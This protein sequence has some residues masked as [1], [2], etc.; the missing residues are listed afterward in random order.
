MVPLLRKKL[1]NI[2]FDPKV[3]FQSGRK[4]FITLPLLNIFKDRY[5]TRKIQ[6]LKLLH[7]YKNFSFSDKN[8]IMQ[9]F[10]Y[11]IAY[12]GHKM[13]GGGDHE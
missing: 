1:N 8:T 6:S 10:I 12:R 9:L 4:K 13:V 3:S 11:C 2:N 7:W 5:G